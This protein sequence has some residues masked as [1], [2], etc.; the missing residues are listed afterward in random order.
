MG[1]QFTRPFN[2]NSFKLFKRETSNLPILFLKTR[3]ILCFT[4][5]LFDIEKSSEILSTTSIVILY[6]KY[7]AYVFDVY[8]PVLLYNINIQT[9]TYICY[10]NQKIFVR[11]C[12]KNLFGGF[13]CDHMDIC[14][15]VF[16]FFGSVNNY[17][18]TELNGVFI[19]G[20]LYTRLRRGAINIK[21]AGLFIFMKEPIY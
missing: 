12:L 19:C 16:I 9:Y 2:L 17:G 13:V 8:E 15:Y 3:I 20:I 6:T 14:I 4:E 18:C 5:N 1:L 21:L 11:L 10:K 7:Y